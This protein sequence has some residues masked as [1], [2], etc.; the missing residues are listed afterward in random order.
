MF[1]KPTDGGASVPR[2]AQ[3]MIRHPNNSGLQRDQVTLLYIPAHFVDEL[4][5]R[6]GDA[7]LFRMEG[8]DFDFGRPEL[9][10]HLHSQWRPRHSRV[11]AKD[12][13]GNDVPA[14]NGRR[15]SRD[16]DAS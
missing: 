9:P 3:V 16:C 5:V 14:A 6:Q 4:A 12:T 1:G 8:G 15:S 13:E 11:E 7:L 10:L 2:E